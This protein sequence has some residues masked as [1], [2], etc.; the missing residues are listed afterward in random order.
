[1]AFMTIAAT[2]SIAQLSA[3]AEYG[4]GS[5]TLYLL[6]AL[7]FLL[8]VALIAAELAT[9]WKGGVFSWVREG[10]GD[11]MG[12]QA[13]WLQWIQSVALYPS[14]LSF[15]AAS[16]AYAFN[17]PALASNGLYTGAMILIVFWGAT[18]VAL[19]GVGTTARIASTGMILGTMIP[20]IALVIMMFVWLGDG[21]TSNTPL[22]IGDVV[23]PW[24]GLSSIVLIVSNF[25]AFAGLEV[26][27]VHVRDMRDPGRGYPRAL[28]LAGVSIVLMYMLGSIAISVIVPNSAINLNAGAAQAF[29]LFASGL[30]LRWIGQVFS[31]LLVVGILAAAISWVAGPSRGLLNVGRQGF[32]PPRLQ[33]VNSAGVQRPILIVQGLIVSVLALA[34]VFIPSVSSAFWILQAMT[35]ILYLTMYVIFFVAAWRLR[36]VR[37]DVPRAFRVPAIGLFAIVGSLAAISAIVIALIPPAQF[38][39]APPIEYAGLLIVGV[40]VLGLSGQII[41]QLRKPGWRSESAEGEARSVDAQ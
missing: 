14:L 1:M 25:I 10:L 39:D 26:N 6:P 41:Y 3:S 19:R 29:T 13:Q 37:P 23:P 2:G 36:R 5:I 20:A 24:A 7:F 38:G 27:A 9:G 40:V 30:G 17:D 21:Q 8:P 18:L 12:F 33:R 32:L 22:E 16:L 31:A 15:A 11:R 35:A 34:F 4:L 28:A